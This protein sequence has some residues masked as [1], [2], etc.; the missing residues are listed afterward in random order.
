MGG[1]SVY[2]IRCLP[3]HL[4]F[5]LFS[6]KLPSSLTP[7]SAVET[8]QAAGLGPVAATSLLTRSSSAAIW[9]QSIE[10]HKRANFMALLQMLY[11][12]CKTCRSPRMTLTLKCVSCWGKYHDF[13]QMTDCSHCESFSLAFLCSRIA[14]H[15]LPFS[16]SQGP[17][18]KK[19]WGRG[20]EQPV[21]SEL[22]PALYP[23]ASPSPQRE[24]IHLSSSPST[25]SVPPRW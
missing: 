24:S 11:R 3:P 10:P 4:R 16:S 8:P 5:L 23:R 15:A 19:Q 17:V 22:T 25:M 6:D 21:T 13:P 14:P 1:A 2:I 9:H 18:R 7:G 12:H 20:F